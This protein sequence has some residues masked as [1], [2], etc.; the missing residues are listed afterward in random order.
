MVSV[1]GIYGSAISRKLRMLRAHGLI[2]EVPRTHLFNFNVT[3]AGRTVLLSVLTTA[4]TSLHELNQ[5]N[6]QAA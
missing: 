1:I 6:R 2:Q 4:K 3:P 5:I